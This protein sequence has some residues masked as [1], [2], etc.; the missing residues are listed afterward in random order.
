LLVGALACLLFGSAL[1]LLRAF[2]H[3]PSSPPVQGSAQVST[4]PS[5]AP[6]SLI[7]APDASE[8][9][10]DVEPAAV[11]PTLSLPPAAASADSAPLRLPKPRLAPHIAQTPHP[12]AKPK[13]DCSVPFTID[14]HGVRIPKRQCL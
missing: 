7:P 9:P 8:A 11:A 13:T 14:D 4:A 6:P 3:N 10:E 5:G 1:L 2:G 12:V